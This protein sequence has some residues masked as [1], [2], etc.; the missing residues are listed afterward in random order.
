MSV[1]VKDNRARELLACWRAGLAAADPRHAVTR[2][3]DELAGSIRH[4]W[5]V[6]L[7]KAAEPMTDAAVSWLDANGGSAA[8]GLIVTP[9]TVADHAL[10][11]VR[12]DHPVPGP[13]SAA[14]AEALG[15][16]CQQLPASAP[17]WVM[18]SGG[19]TS[20]IGGPA[21]GLTEADLQESYRVLLESGLDIRRM[22]QVRKRLSRWGGGQLLT[23]L[24]DRPILQLVVS[25]VPGDDLAAIG[26]GPL[27]PDRTPAAEVLQHLEAAGAR[28]RMP[29][30][31]VARLQALAGARGEGVPPDVPALDRV[32]S[33]VVVSNRI[34]MAAAA[35]AGRRLGWEVTMIDGYLEGEARDCGARLARQVLTIPGPGPVLLVAGGETT[36]RLPAGHR[37]LGGRCQELALSA[38]E[39]LRRAPAPVLLLAAGT[40]G[41]DGP[42]EAAGALVDR[43]TWNRIRQS[44]GDPA[45]AL[46]AHASHDA[47][48]AVGALVHTGPT[49]T[50]VADLVLAFRDAGPVRETRLGPAAP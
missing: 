16:L 23:A 15:R 35:E 32:V 3:L 46:A 13:R 2:A 37:R 19:T 8:G 48:A 29:A 41:R 44:G 27:I 42:T 20:L 38:A 24:G 1:G 31:A 33:R 25:D 12:G 21:T 50:N 39:T 11:S 28:H 47:L 43:E 40:D 30:R 7:G 4:P 9:S 49:G 14:A 6:A 45:Q 26:S 22:N 17:V 36:V 34:A 18:L 10:P 5:I